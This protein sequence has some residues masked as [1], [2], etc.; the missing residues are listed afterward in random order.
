M[1]GGVTSLTKLDS[2]LYEEPLSGGGNSGRAINLENL[3]VRTRALQ[4]I[5]DLLKSEKLAMES[6]SIAV[7]EH[8]KSRI[9]DVNPRPKRRGR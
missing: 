1:H 2:L 9:K 5:S 8:E 3:Q 4:L 7:T 6:L